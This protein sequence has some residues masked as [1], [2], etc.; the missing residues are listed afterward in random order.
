MAYAHVRV[1]GEGGSL[2]LLPK[3]LPLFP[4]PS[5]YPFLFFLGS[6]EPFF[7]E[8]WGG[9]GGGRTEEGCAG[10]RPL[11]GFL[12]PF[13]VLL[14]AGAGFDKA[15]QTVRVA[16]GRDTFFTLSRVCSSNKPWANFTPSRI[17]S[18][19]RPSSPGLLLFFFVVMLRGTE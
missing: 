10:D 17:P 12:C 3:S 2:L 6:Q 5:P 8:R 4:P 14:R 16:K 19:A 9:E 7:W 13:K 18:P 15:R 1:G 11:P